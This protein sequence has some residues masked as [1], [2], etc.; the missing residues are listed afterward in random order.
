MSARF[1]PLGD[2][3][4]DAAFGQPG[5]LLNSGGGTQ[6][7]RAGSLDPIQQV[8]TG[9]AEVKT[10]HLWPERFHDPAFFFIKRLPARRRDARRCI[11]SSP[12]VV[13]LQGF[14]PGIKILFTQRRFLVAE[15]VQVEGLVRGSPY[16]RHL[17]FNL[18]GIEHG[19]G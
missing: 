3:C 9:Q 14:P 11:D 12:A 1:N 15:E 6:N 18:R 8:L 10:D 13:G 19:A 5:R 16:A 17:V 4:V 2:D 7:Q